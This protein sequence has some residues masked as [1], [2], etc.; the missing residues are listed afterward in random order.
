M[1]DN[2]LA[3]G[4]NIYRLG[5]ICFNHYYSLDIPLGPE[6]MATI[7]A[8]IDLMYAKQVYFLIG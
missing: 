6:F 4:Q 1:E 3:I 5:R 8:G 2:Y 7:T